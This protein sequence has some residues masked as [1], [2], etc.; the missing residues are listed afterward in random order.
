MRVL[1]VIRSLD[2]GGTQRQC[3]ELAKGLTSKG[4][5]VHIAVFYSGE[6][7]EREVTEIP[8]IQLHD[9]RKRGRWHLLPL[10]INFRRLLSRYSFEI[11]YGFLSTGN[12]L[13]LISKMTRPNQRPSVFWGIR[14][15]NTDY[16][17][18]DPLL[19]T[20]HTLENLFS[21]FADKII[22]NSEAGQSF[23]LERGFPE[24]KLL[25]IHNGIDTEHYKSSKAHKYKIR[26]SLGIGDDSILVGIV[27]RI[28]PKKDLATFV[29]AA[30]LL[31]KKVDNLYFLCIGGNS[32]RY[33]DYADG[34]KLLCRNEGI[35]E[36]VQWLGDRDDINK[37]LSGID[38]FSLTSSYGEGF[39]NVIA[40]AMACNT[41]CVVTNCGDSKIIVG[42]IG[43]IVPVRDPKALFQA[44]LALIALT[45]EERERLGAMS[46]ARITSLFSVDR[47]VEK[48]LYAI[49]EALNER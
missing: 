43:K 17:V 20:A 4:I 44:W 42:D 7:L 31:S 19:K 33:K 29:K 18:Y 15:S 5:E 36:I 49:Y 26:A 38:I 23:C 41:P 34:L 48:T 16:N 22:T 46:R 35:D 3:I 40:E 2:S 32:P 21:R 14:D 24:K 6:R 27:A 11:V 9:L 28:H 45:K 10:L 37:L 12:L 8:Q 1:L 13:A 25:T 30:K 47:M 39:P